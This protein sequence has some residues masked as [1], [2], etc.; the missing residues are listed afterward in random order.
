MAH[1]TVLVYIMDSFEEVDLDDSLIFTL[2]SSLHVNNSER[3][4][5]SLSRGFISAP[6]QH[7]F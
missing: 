7:I 1:L 5:R 4:V 6:I 2:P 3:P